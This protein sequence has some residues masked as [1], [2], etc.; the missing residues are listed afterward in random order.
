MTM[1]RSTMDISS[2]SLCSI[3][4][5]AGPSEC[6]RPKRPPLCSLRM[7]L[8]SSSDSAGLRPPSGSSSSRSSGSVAM[9]RAT[10]SL[11]KPPWDSAAAGSSAMSEM[12]TNSS[13]SIAFASTP[14]SH[15]PRRRA[16]G[17]TSGTITLATMGRCRNGRVFWNVAAT[18]RST[19]SQGRKA[20]MS[21][22]AKRMRPWSGLRIFVISRKRV[23]FPAPLGPIS[24]TISS[25]R[26][27]N[28]TSFT[29]VRPPKRLVRC[30][31]R[32]N[33][34]AMGRSSGLGA[35]VTQLAARDLAHVGL[36]NFSAELDHVGDLVV[37]EPLAAVRLDLLLADAAA[38]VGLQHHHGLDPLADRRIG[39]AD[40]ARRL[41]VRVAIQHVLDVLREDG[42]ALVLD[43]VLGP[44]VEVEIALVVHAD[45][46]AGPHP[47]H[48]GELDEC[49]IRLLG[50]APVALH[51]VGSREHQLAGQPRRDELQRLGVHDGGEHIGH[52]PAKRPWLGAAD[53]IQL[54]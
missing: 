24:P 13:A 17:A 2:L 14:L 44:V 42:M 4:R 23:V 1:T 25:R 3:M 54:A 11:F 39:H 34:S 47:A 52:R 15:S 5:T 48:A 30:S 40:H 51:H 10:S 18:P 49:P 50:P 29:A 37:G 19:T 12:P 41:H 45:D 21:S 16:R 6:S 33:G 53:G 35:F 36:G 38:R 8:A 20:V 32:K 26:S 31:T 46:V 43:E 22:P 28:P 7:D 27:S 9:A